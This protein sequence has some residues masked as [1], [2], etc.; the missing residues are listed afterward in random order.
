M[1]IHQQCVAE[2]GLW[3]DE[4]FCS[5]FTSSSFSRF[6][7][8]KWKRKKNFFYTKSSLSSLWCVLSM[9]A[10]RLWDKH[11]IMISRWWEWNHVLNTIF[12][13]KKVGSVRKSSWEENFNFFSRKQKNESQ[14]SEFSSCL[15][16]CEFGIEQ[17]RKI[18]RKISWYSCFW[19]ELNWIFICSVRREKFWRRWDW[20]TVRRIFFCVQRAEA[21][22]RA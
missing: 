11:F 20:R 7:F 13:L 9:I 2:R 17:Q 16:S 14:S 1:C 21:E 18:M 10:F 8:S 6:R 15:R 12:N 19:A 4:N 5:M 22:Q 3:S